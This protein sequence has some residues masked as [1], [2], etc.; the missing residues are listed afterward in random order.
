MTPRIRMLI[1]A[2]VVLAG[3]AGTALVAS[4]TSAQTPPTPGTVT[5]RYDSIGRIV[6][7]IYPANSAAYNYDSGGNRTSFTLN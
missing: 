4:R 5:Y 7:D 1:I 2:A 3:A 6:Q